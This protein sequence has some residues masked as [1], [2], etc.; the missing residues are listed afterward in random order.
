MN[1]NTSIAEVNF[2][3]IQA[4]NIPYETATKTSINQSST[5][6]YKEY[7]NLDQYKLSKIKDL[8]I[9]PT[10]SL[11]K[12][13]EE[14]L[15]TCLKIKIDN[16]EADITRQRFS[17]CSTARDRCRIERLKRLNP[18][19]LE[20]LMHLSEEN[21]HVL[22]EFIEKLYDCLNDSIKSFTK[23]STIWVAHDVNKD[24]LIKDNNFRDNL[25]I[26]LVNFHLERLSDP[27]TEQSEV[28]HTKLIN[29][30]ITSNT[31]IYYMSGEY[32]SD[33]S[34]QNISIAIKDLSR[35]KYPDQM[36]KY[37]FHFDINKQEDSKAIKTLNSIKKALNL[38]VFKEQVNNWVNYY[39]KKS[40]ASLETIN[41]NQSTSATDAKL[42]TLKNLSVTDKNKLCD[43]IAY[44]Y[45]SLVIHKNKLVLNSKKIPRT[46]ILWDINSSITGEYIDK[47][48]VASIKYFINLLSNPQPENEQCIDQIDSFMNDN[49]FLYQIYIEYIDDNNN[50]AIANAV[51]Q[52]KTDLVN[53]GDNSFTLVSLIPGEENT[54]KY[55][56]IRFDIKTTKNS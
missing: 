16:L 34:I 43:F 36:S 49:D 47:L 50:F 12:K 35:Y 4:S 29:S 3:N 18:T 5:S 7:K 33:N 45:Q 23:K 46:K 8:N 56:Y 31:N 14:L 27:E 42:A 22:C 40:I 51:S 11:V 26:S 13:P 37:R 2:P 48:V 20:K 38:T 24:D 32:V 1:I 10:A 15:N 52:K 9:L 25:I 21:K 41:V 39:I 28:T 17:L 6:N 44:F 54:D 30:F 55:S 53:T 19:R